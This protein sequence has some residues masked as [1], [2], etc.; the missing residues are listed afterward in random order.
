LS[1]LYGIGC[2]VCTELRETILEIA[3]M[4][5]HSASEPTMLL[6]QA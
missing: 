2:Q 1:F 6:N 4:R 5:M 3:F